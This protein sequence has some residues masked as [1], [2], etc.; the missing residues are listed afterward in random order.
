MLLAVRAFEESDP[1]FLLLSA[2]ERSKSTRRALVV[3]GLSEADPSTASIEPSRRAEA[4]TRRARLLFDLLMRR[5][6][7]LRRVIALSSVAGATLP[8][9][10]LIA[11]VIGALGNALGPW[12]RINL[13]AFPLFGLWIWNLVVYLSI[14]VRAVYS[15]RLA[16][17]ARR[18]QSHAN[19]IGRS[20]AGRLVRV[21]LRRHLDLSSIEDAGGQTELERLEARAV[22]RY[23]ALWHR[24][25][26]T[27]LGRRVST[28]LHLGSA[29]VVA[30]L[31]GGMYLRALAFEYRVG[32]EST[33]LGAAQVQV[34]FDLVLGPAAGLLGVE[35]PD[36]S[37]LRV[38]GG[39][40]TGGGPAAIWIHLFAL[41]SVG[42]VLIP[43]IALAIYSAVGAARLSHRLPIAIDDPYYR[44]AFV[45]IRGGSRRVS[46][47]PYSYRPHQNTTHMLSCL[48]AEHFGA[49]AVIDQ[50]K[51]LAYGAAWP[52]SSEATDEVSTRD[53]CRVLLFSLA[54]TPELEVHGALL[55]EAR[56]RSDETGDE[57]LVGIDTAGYRNQ[58]A[59]RR[60]ERQ[61]AWSA[62]VEDAGLEAAL[63]D[64]VRPID[65]AA[66]VEIAA[67]IYRPAAVQPPR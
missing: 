37:G 57:L 52:E 34:L 12:R 15:R 18:G 45:A 8:T 53:V 59:K 43:R 1:E 38:T 61:R 67:A 62:L 39:D 3:T 2:A 29:C 31:L 54:Q 22:T 66:L 9:V 44:R 30:G 65:E 51:A 36:V 47:R 5:V 17:S 60:A 23:G 46:I 14:A 32:W 6:P 10:M 25:A 11:L 35:V 27:L 13:L 41:T 64:E 20:L 16:D 40:P 49:R 24:T 21:A 33:L 28:A 26:N 19:R 50:R 42:L 58:P 56:E 7:G 63:I 4:L 48:L 55:R